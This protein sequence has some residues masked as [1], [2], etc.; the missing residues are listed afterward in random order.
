[1]DKVLNYFLR[2]VMAPLMLRTK[3]R[4]SL[5][6]IPSR[7]HGVQGESILH[8][9]LGFGLNRF[10]PK[11]NIPVY[12]LPR[13]HRICTGSQH[14]HPCKLSGHVRSLRGVEKL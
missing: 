8:N 6:V 9:T 2:G 10:K 3:V 14:I 7:Q 13:G 1:M 4:L 12:Y 11:R 5:L